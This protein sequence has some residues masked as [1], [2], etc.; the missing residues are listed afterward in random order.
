MGSQLGVNLQDN[1]S[2]LEYNLEQTAHVEL[3]QAVFALEQWMAVSYPAFVME[4]VMLV[5]PALLIHPISWQILMMEH[6]GSQR[7]IVTR[8]PV[9]WLNFL[10]ELWF[11]SVS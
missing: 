9:W 1:P 11:K 2:L 5:T 3:H 4:C 7:T 6:G 10:L 8:E